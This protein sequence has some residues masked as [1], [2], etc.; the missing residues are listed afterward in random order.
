[1]ASSRA[2]ELAKDILVAW[3]NYM[4]STQVTP[5]ELAA[6]PRAAETLASMYQ[7]IVK[8]IDETSPPMSS[9]PPTI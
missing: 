2:Q 3:L 1:M 6:A 9:T 5:Q 8:A 7:V 4:A